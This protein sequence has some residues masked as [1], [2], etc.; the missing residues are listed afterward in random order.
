MKPAKRHLN[1]ERA[2]FDRIPRQQTDVTGKR[3]Y[4]LTEF[5]F[6]ALGLFLL[7]VGGEFALRGAIGMARRLRISPAIIGLTV[8]GFGTSA[9]EL[10]VTIRAVVGGS[11]DIA[12]GNAIGSNIANTLL[13]VGAGALVHSL[14]CDPRA[15]RRD[16]TAMLL[17]TVLLCGLGLTGGIA[18][19]QGAAMLGL[20]AAFLWWSYMHDRRHRDAG[21]ELHEGAAE[22]TGGIP[23]RIPAIAGFILVGLAGLAYGAAMLVESAV[24][25]AVAAGVSESIIGLTLVAI[26]T[27]LPELAATLVAAYRRHADIAIANVLGSNLFNILAVLGTGALF[28]QLRFSAHIVTID[29]WVMLAAAAVLLPM[30]VTGWRVSRR[31]GAIL[32]CAYAAYLGFLA[33]GH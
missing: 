33:T 26:G 6:L 24:A 13:I 20:L 18:A 31:E 15:V 29:L 30:M 25:L 12:V 21:T 19:W 23:A 10:V 8:M 3:V 28:G 4:L 17:A 2:I 27:S 1:D 9:P 14:G 32:L 11:A 16:G 5:L 7:I 22:E